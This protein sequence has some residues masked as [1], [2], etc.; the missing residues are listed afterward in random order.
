[1]LRSRLSCV[2]LLALAGCSSEPQ[3]TDGGTDAATDAGA[4]DAGSRDGGR[5]AGRDGGYPVFT[6]IP[7]S[8]AAAGRESCAFGRGAM[9]WETIGEEHP[10][11]RDIPINHFILLMQENRSFDHYFGM[12]PGVDGI[13][14]GF[15]N[16]DATGTDVAAFH[17]DEYCV[18][19]PGHGWNASHEEY[20]GGTNEGFILANDPNGVRAM[21]YFDDS[22]LPF[23]WDFAQTFAMS[24]HHH[25]S[26]LGPTWVNRFYYLSG[27]SFGLISNDPI[28]TDRIPTDGD[29]VIFEQLDRAFVDY[30]V[31]YNGAP[32]VWIGYP[33][34]SFGRGSRNRV[35]PIDE[36]WEQLDRGELPPVVFIDPAWNFA[37]TAGTDEHPP[38]NPQ[39]GQ[40]WVRE[41]VTRVMQSPIWADTAI[42][43]TYDEHGGF[44]DHVP[45][46]EVCPPGDFGPDLD[47]SDEPGDFTRLGFRVPMVVASPYARTGYVSSRV[48]DHA[49][50]LRLLQA[51]FLL[52]AM[53]GRDANA[54]PL[55]D[56]FDFESPPNTVTAADLAD[57]PIDPDHV[58]AC[59]AAF[60]PTL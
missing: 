21:G 1:M 7:E 37:G 36:F 46:P 22:D 2:I 32:F 11:G 28:P 15:T 33:H 4:L 8:E 42:I 23:Y 19:D 17:T 41:V 24:D 50:V 51:K 10:L 30:R 20:A 29:H 59:R 9:P 38:A 44:F 40:A 55:L 14:G 16:P 56:M 35:R 27:T 58:A 39:H 60:P 57:A 45:P 49:S 13:Q 5:D 18:E 43:F 25:C 26:L 3:V 53:T 6:R 48:T 31:Y 34:V 52:P 54:W 12:M 47:P